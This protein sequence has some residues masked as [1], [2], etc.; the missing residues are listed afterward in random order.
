GGRSRPPQGQRP[1][2]GAGLAAQEDVGSGAMKSWFADAS[3]SSKLTALMT[4]STAIALVLAGVA[5]GAYETVTFRPT[6]PPKV[7]T[8]AEI[9]GRNSTAA[10]AFSDHAVARDILKALESEPSI[11]DGIIFD[12]QGHEF[13]SYSSRNRPATLPTAP[14]EPGARAENGSLI[15]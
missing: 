14:G 8:V 1:A 6:L 15:V 4:L 12:A 10:L 5:V 13:A 2:A 7:T 9:V 3:I 11:E